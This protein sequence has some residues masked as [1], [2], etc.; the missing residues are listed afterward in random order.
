MGDFLTKVADLAAELAEAEK[1][2]IQ[3]EQ[4]DRG[5]YATLTVRALKPA[6]GEITLKGKKVNGIWTVKNF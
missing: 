5:R 2:E 1:V 6:E 3:I 4:E